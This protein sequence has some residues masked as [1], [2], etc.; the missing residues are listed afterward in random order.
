MKKI[1]CLF[2][3]IILLFAVC[4]CNAKSAQNTNTTKKEC[5]EHTYTEKTE[6]IPTTFKEGKKKLSCTKCG[7]KTEEILPATDS[8]KILCI[9]N[10]YSVDSMEYLYDIAKD[11][12][13]KNIVL[14]NLYL[15]ACNLD[16]HWQ[17]I[18]GAL[19]AYEYFFNSN[20][21][22]VKT[23]NVSVQSPLR[24][25][26][27]DI[28]VLQIADVNNSY[29][30]LKNIVE[31][32]ENNSINPD[33]RI[34]WN[35]N[36]AYQ[37]D[38]THNN[39]RHY[40]NN[41]LTMYD[42]ILAFATSNITPFGKIDGIIPSG[43]AIQNLRTTQLGDTL[44]RDGYHLSYD[45][46]RYCVALTWYSYLTQQN[47]YKINWIPEKYPHLKDDLDLIKKSVTDAITTPMGITQQ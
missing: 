37:Q 7:Y 20:G 13:V 34:Y 24:D 33:I 2:I 29:A 41:Q 9:G 36:W 43:T 38:S 19:D 39:F 12:G 26:S 45:Y 32:I 23:P 11:G 30:N 8:L 6:I 5:K 42:R 15:A 46:G 47:A 35:L 10:S 16:R 27:W 25:N 21:K 1:I 28:V 22:W 3:T 14:G 18:N 40:D 4:G 31:Y 17:N 44:T